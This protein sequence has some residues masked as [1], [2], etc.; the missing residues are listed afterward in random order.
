ML[1]ACRAA[2]A[3]RRTESTRADEPDP[4]VARSVRTWPDWSG[5]ERE[6]VVRDTEADRTAPPSRCRVARS[7]SAAYPEACTNCPSRVER[8]KPDALALELDACTDVPTGAARHALDPLAAPAP[9]PPASR[10][11]DALA[12]AALVALVAL[13]SFT[14]RVTLRTTF[15]VCTRTSRPSALTDAIE[16]VHVGTGEFRRFP[17]RLVLGVVR[18]YKAALQ[19]HANLNKLV[20][21]DSMA[22]EASGAR[23]EVVAELRGH[24]DVVWGV[25]WHP[26]RALLASCSADRSVRLWAPR[27]EGAEWE[28][29]CTLDGVAG[30]TVRQVAWSPDGGLLCA[31]SFDGT[32]TV[33]EIPRALEDPTLLATLEAHQNEVKGCAFAPSGAQLA[34]CGRDKSVIVWAVDSEGEYDCQAVLQGH[35]QDVKS[36]A[37]HPRAA[38]TL[39]STSYDDSLRVWEDDGSGDW[40]CAQTLGSQPSTVWSVAFEPGTCGADALRMASCDGKGGLRVWRWRATGSASAAADRGVVEGAGR[41]DLAAERPAVHERAAFC[42]DW[43]LSDAEVASSAPASSASSSSSSSSSLSSGASSRSPLIATCGGDN[44][45][46][47]CTVRD[48]SG[49]DETVEELLRVPAAHGIA[50]VNAVRFG[51]AAGTRRL[52]ASAGDD[53][54]VKIW[55]VL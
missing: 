33:W 55:R 15:V 17:L 18:E 26:S 42:V 24:D 54:V 53:G 6:A 9:P 2:S 4:A 37:W 41:W 29:V 7:D 32:A 20:H 39:V 44:A 46:V 1:S 25:A 31:V 8:E 13:V 52:L 48:S 16:N 14:V 50:E 11:T 35:T 43:A 30:R 38:A 36:V 19:H 40:V 49:E 27:G 45:I 34:T 10:A 28:C 23:M 47:L 22:A 5:T 12:P 3:S 51:H 21:I